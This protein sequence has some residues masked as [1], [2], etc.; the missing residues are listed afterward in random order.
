MYWNA[1]EAPSERAR[2]GAMTSLGAGSPAAFP[3]GSGQVDPSQPP[4]ET[5]RA[6][7][8]GASH[9]IPAG[10]GSKAWKFA[11]VPEPS[12]SVRDLY[13]QLSV[14]EIGPADVDRLAAFAE[15]L[16]ACTFFSLGAGDTKEATG[17]RLQELCRDMPDDAR[18]KSDAWI[19]K[20]ASMGDERA[21]ALFIGS[22]YFFPQQVR[23][24]IRDPERYAEYKKTTMQ[25]VGQ[26]IASGYQPALGRMSDLLMSN[27]QEPDPFRAWAYHYAATLAEGDIRKQ[28]DALTIISKRLPTDQ[29]ARAKQ[30]GEEIFRKCC[31]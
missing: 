16:Q 13:S 27:W 21:K 26:L 7:A 28:Q 1:D 22:T 6:A 30:L 20:L 23:N 4:V 9:R 5:A 2:P 3:L 14:R 15:L 24:I 29:H 25:Y 11:R 10:P 17:I 18:Q 19:E 31:T 12:A 8:Q